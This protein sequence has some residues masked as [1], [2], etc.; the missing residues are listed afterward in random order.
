MT[1][2]GA[3]VVADHKGVVVG[4]QIDYL[5]FGLVAPLETDDTGA[6]HGISPCP[7]NLLVRNL[8]L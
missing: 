7:T 4:Q 2:V 3:A 5:P 1:G 8:W 6:G